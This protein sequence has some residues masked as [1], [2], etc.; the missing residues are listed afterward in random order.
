L[1]GDFPG[2]HGDVISGA[3]ATGIVLVLLDAGGDVRGE[4]H[5]FAQT[6][7]GVVHR[8]VVGLQPDDLTAFVDAFELALEQFALIQASPE[9]LVGTAVDQFRAAEQTVMFTLEFSE[10]VTHAC[11]KILVGRENAAVEVEFDH[12]HRPVDCLQ[13][14]VGLAF[15]LHLGRHVHGELDHFDHTSRGILDRVVIGFQPDRLALAV[16]PFEGAGLELTVF[17]AR[18]QFGVL[19]AAAKLRSAEQAMRLAYHLFGAVTH[20]FEE[21]VIG[22]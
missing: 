18:P 9:V 15:L 19:R 8:V 6:P 17:Q 22:L 4:F 5:H 2:F 12:R 13:F 20:G 14:G 21:V 3:G 11:Q 10:G 16:D 1:L 7:R